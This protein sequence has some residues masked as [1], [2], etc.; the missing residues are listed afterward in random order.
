MK[1]VTKSILVSTL[2]AVAF[3]ALSVGSTFALF[4]SQSKTEIN[5]GSGKIDVSSSI[6]NFKTYSCEANADGDRTDENNNKYISKETEVSGIFTNSGT[7]GFEN[8]TITLSRVT[9][10]DR[11]T[12]DIGFANNSNVNFKYRGVYRLVSEDKT[13]AKGLVTKTN[14]FAVNEVV[15]Y[16]GLL[17]GES[18]W[19]TWIYGSEE[20]LPTISF[21][22][23]LPID[24]NNTYQNKEAQFIFTLQAVQG[25]AHTTNEDSSI[26][27]GIEDMSQ[28][29]V[30]VAEEDLTLQASNQANDIRVK[31]V[32]PAE[33]EE[34]NAG[35]KVEL[36]VSEM[37]LDRKSSTN[38]VLDFDVKLKVNGTETHSFSEL[39][40]VEIYVGEDLL[41]NEVSH[42]GVVLVKNEDYT[43]NSNTGIISFSTNSF[44][45]FKVKYTG[46]ITASGQ[47]IEDTGEDNE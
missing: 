43:Y 29:A 8:S 17:E 9:P 26:H 12:F 36:V 10:G 18:D 30:A 21:D 20:V 22:I 23:E 42:N 39:I 15:A 47:D 19:K 35:D 16:N 27:C 31:T 11:V 25:N 32:I 2:L 34:V 13:L 1:K 5:V 38:S 41:I 45:P 4:T 7:A 46:P 24:K 14:L 37:E 44:S 33:A 3:G 40:A 28:E 6:S